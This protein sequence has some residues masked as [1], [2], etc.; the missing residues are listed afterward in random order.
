MN[1]QDLD[2]QVIVDAL[3]SAYGGEIVADNVSEEE[4]ME[5]YAENFCEWVNGVVIKM[6]PVHI[7]HDALF[8]FL[9]RL[10]EMYFALKPVGQFVVAPFVMW[11]NTKSRREPDLQIILNQH[12][13]R[14]KPTYIEGAADICIEIVS[15]GSVEIDY[16]KKFK[17]YEQAGVGEYWILDPLRQD[18]LFYR[19]NDQ[20]VFQRHN[21]DADGSYATPLLPQFTLHVPTLWHDPLPDAVEVGEMVKWMRGGQ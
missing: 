5:K 6:S 2:E 7:D 21:T 10:F 8:R 14:L 9:I 11:M 12:L 4:Y 3:L 13:D 20:N 15:P 18:A 1:V 19:R 17:E 16:G